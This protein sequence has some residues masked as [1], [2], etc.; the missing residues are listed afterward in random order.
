MLFHVTTPDLV[1]FHNRN[2]LLTDKTT[3]SPTLASSTPRFNFLLQH[4]SDVLDSR[5]IHVYAQNTKEETNQIS[6]FHFVEHTE[7]N[8]KKKRYFHV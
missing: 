7:L 1:F 8:Q 2:A 4:E 5:P 6:Y 3:I